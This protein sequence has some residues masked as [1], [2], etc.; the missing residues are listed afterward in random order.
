MENPDRNVEMITL[1]HAIE[2]PVQAD[3]RS[4]V[5]TSMSPDTITPSP[6]PVDVESQS[7]VPRPVQT[8]LSRLAK[9]SP[10]HPNKPNTI[11]VIIGLVLAAIAIW[12]AL[13]SAR[14]TQ[15]ATALAQ[16]SAAREFL[17]YCESVSSLPFPYCSPT[18][19]LDEIK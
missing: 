9:H 17:A 7:P 15:N 13:Q 2:P 12:P 4:T 19:S 6:Q 3:N 1:D 5:L 14:D 11:L 8:R 10:F 18:P 16:W